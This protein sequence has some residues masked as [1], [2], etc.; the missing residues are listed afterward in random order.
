VS[1]IAAHLGS[2]N[3]KEDLMDQRE[4]TPSSVVSNRLTLGALTLV[5]AGVA[6]L[7][8]GILRAGVPSDPARNLEFALGANSFAFRFG[9]ALTGVSLT[10][11]ILGLIAL[12]AYLSRTKAER[13]ALIGLVVTAGFLVLFLPVTGFAAYVV[14]AIGHL[15]EQ[16]QGEMV[17]VMDQTFLEPFVPIPFFGGILWNI[18][19]ILLGIAIWRSERLW[20][21]SGLLFVL[22]GIIGI[23]GFLDVEVLGL[24]SSVLLGLA[25]LVV[26]AALFRAV[27]GETWTP[28]VGPESSVTTD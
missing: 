21:W 5:L 7:P 6:Q 25:Q 16:G 12:Y 20:K 18:G 2:I 27:R 28:A 22:F 1:G 4:A 19:C 26:G 24:A 14:P 23:P 3:W 10:F 8:T 9:M 15:A 11:F 13:L 17:Q